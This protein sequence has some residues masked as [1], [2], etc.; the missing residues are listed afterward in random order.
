MSVP[1]AVS[2]DDVLLTVLEL[3]AVG[4]RNLQDDTRRFN[5]LGEVE[6]MRRQQVRSIEGH[7]GQAEKQ[8]ESLLWQID[9][10]DARAVIEKVW[11]PLAVEDV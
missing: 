1:I 5:L 7:L 4:T 10:D 8:V 11:G 2:I 6:W 9:T 3:V